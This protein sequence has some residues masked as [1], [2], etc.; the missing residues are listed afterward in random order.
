MH[1]G[2]RGEIELQPIV[3]RQR[4]RLARQVAC[5]RHRANLKKSYASVL[6]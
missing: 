3:S 1:D 5:S 2:A 4:G 6:S